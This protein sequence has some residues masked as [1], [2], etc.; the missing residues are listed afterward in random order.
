MSF[1]KQ[2]LRHAVVRLP[3]FGQ[4]VKLKLLELITLL[5]SLTASLSFC[6]LLSV[7][8]TWT[9]YH[10]KQ[11]TNSNCNF[12]VAC[13]GSL[14]GNDSYLWT[15]VCCESSAVRSWSP[16]SCRKEFPVAGKSPL[17][18]WKFICEWFSAQKYVQEWR[19]QQL[20]CANNKPLA[21]INN[22]SL[23]SHVSWSDPNHVLTEWFSIIVIISFID[24]FK[25]KTVTFQNI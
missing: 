13:F 4:E 11:V 5:H 15:C 19:V 23:L 18:G 24:T 12:L 21:S 1:F 14:E 20:I 22:R 10:A 2:N 16:T 9:G 17:C 25:I 6:I 7:Q 8:T 3:P